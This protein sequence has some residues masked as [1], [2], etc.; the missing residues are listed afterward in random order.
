MINKNFINRYG[1]TMP[2]T[3]AS[4]K[5]IS[6]ND[7]LANKYFGTKLP[8]KGSSLHYLEFLKERIQLMKT[9]IVACETAVELYEHLCGYRQS[10]A[11]SS[12]DGE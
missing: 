4:I 7:S 3:E 6:H 12:T 8:R 9:W 2:A 11:P 5:Q 10:V 1:D